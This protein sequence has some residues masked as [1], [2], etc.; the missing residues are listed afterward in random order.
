MTQPTQTVQIAPKVKDTFCTVHPKIKESC[1]C[2]LCI[3][4]NNLKMN[5]WLIRESKDK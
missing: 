5:K 4:E 1:P 2:V 3:K